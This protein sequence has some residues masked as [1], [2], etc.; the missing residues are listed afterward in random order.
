MLLS[1]HNPQHA[2]S[3]AGQL[4]ALSAG[5]VAAFG[6]PEAVLTQA[7]IRQLYDVNVDFAETKGGRVIVPLVSEQ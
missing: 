3:Y 2:L 4:L 1:T 6:K 5:Q 7:L